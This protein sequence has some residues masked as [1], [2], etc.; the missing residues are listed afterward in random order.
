MKSVSGSTDSGCRLL[1]TDSECLRLNRLWGVYEHT[2]KNCAG[3]PAADGFIVACVLHNAKHSLSDCPEALPRALWEDVAWAWIEAQGGRCDD[4]LPF[5]AAFCQTVPRI[6]YANYDRDDPTREPLGFRPDC[7]PFLFLDEANTVTPVNNPDEIPP[8]YFCEMV[9]TRRRRAEQN[10]L[11]TQMTRPGAPVV[12]NGGTEGADFDHDGDVD[13]NDDS[14]A[15]KSSVQQIPR[16][17][18]QS[19]PE[20]AGLAPR[21]TAT[22]LF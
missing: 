12:D 6:K 7:T 2:A 19:A 11:A 1:A 5:T 14:A 21:C 3:P 22:K 16:G 17:S 18:H 15:G 20:Y 10:Q 13:E 4:A 9:T 8:C